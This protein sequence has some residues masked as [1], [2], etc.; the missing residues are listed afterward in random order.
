MY[1]RP[2][3]KSPLCMIEWAY[4]MLPLMKGPKMSEDPMKGLNMLKTPPPS[5]KTKNK[6]SIYLRT[7]I[8]DEIQVEADRQ[9]RSVSW[10]LQRAWILS[11][12]H[13]KAQSDLFEEVS[14]VS[15]TPQEPESLELSNDSDEPQTHL[16]ENT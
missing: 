4:L 13:I 6:K 15:I 3:Y 5:S 1:Q 7:T 12:D 11:R 10:I 8:L 16:S 2:V 9:D 14:Q